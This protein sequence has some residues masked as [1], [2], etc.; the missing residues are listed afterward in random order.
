MKKESELYK[1][2]IQSEIDE[3]K[4]KDDLVMQKKRKDAE[5]ERSIY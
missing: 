5:I 3:I 4:A 2:V 1:M